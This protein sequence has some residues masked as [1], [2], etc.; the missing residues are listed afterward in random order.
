MQM[1]ILSVLI[2][3]IWLLNKINWKNSCKSISAFLE[4]TYSIE[5]N[6]MYQQGINSI[7]R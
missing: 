7:F 1:L 4:I 3:Q 2:Y 5:L 6:A